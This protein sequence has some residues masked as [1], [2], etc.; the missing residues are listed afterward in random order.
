MP[1]P[2][3]GGR[4]PTE[5]TVCKRPRPA[6]R[7]VEPVWSPRPL[8]SLW[9][10]SPACGR[11]NRHQDRARGP[12]VPDSDGR[13]GA[14][15]GGGGAHSAPHRLLARPASPRLRVHLDGQAWRLSRAQAFHVLRQPV[16]RQVGGRRPSRRG[17]RHRTLCDITVLIIPVMCRGSRLD[18]RARRQ[19][20]AAGGSPADNP[21]LRLSGCSLWQPAA[22]GQG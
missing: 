22:K 5:S 3:S 2:N 12:H 4:L 14:G 10:G 1:F 18:P 19:P 17:R 15:G 16:A 11:P 20:A 13:E 9:P 8:S 6:G 7:R 21:A